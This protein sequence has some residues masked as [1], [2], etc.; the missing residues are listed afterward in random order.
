[1]PQF[2]DTS[3]KRR[4]TCHPHLIDLM[5]E[6]IKIMDFTIVCGHRGKL[7]QNTA[8]MTGRSKLKFPNSKHNKTPSLAIDIA[9][10][11]YKPNGAMWIDWNDI[12]SFVDLS[13]VIFPIA[14]KM[15][16]HVRW[17]GDFN[18]DGRKTTNDAWDKGH[19]ELM[20]IES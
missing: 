17:G 9:P 6:A 20:G 5:N 11:K 10:V 7:A 8:F 1:M 16:I 2:N 19:W 14:D 13:Q 4:D 18:M 3:K 15:G 12:Q